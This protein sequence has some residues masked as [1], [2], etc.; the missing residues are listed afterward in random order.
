M[1]WSGK[2]FI[3]CERGLDPG[4]W[5]EPLNALSN[6]AFVLAALLGLALWRARPAGRREIVTLV[7]IALVLAIGI[8]SFL[9]HTLATRWA[10]VAD[11]GPITVFMVAY[12]AYALRRFVALPWWG[13]ALGLATF[14]VALPAAATL[15]CGAGPCLNG[16]VGYLPAFAALM[17]IGG[18]LLVRG[19]AAGPSLIAAGLIFLAAL[20][21]RSLDR[22]LCPYTILTASGGIGTH[23]LWHVLNGALL[24]VL[25]R[26]AILHGAPPPVTRPAV[27]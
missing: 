1:N 25:L 9:F 16:S 4:F 19:R 10:A 18:V 6:A 13:T 14:L 7:L 12:L 27:A 23:F 8:G 5:A 17:L 15:R 24:F 22:T 20:T 3:Y 11:T 2:I 21:A 26:A